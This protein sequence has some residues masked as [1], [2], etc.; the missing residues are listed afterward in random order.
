MR[1]SRQ[2]RAAIATSKVFLCLVTPDWQGD[3]LCQEEARY[4]A[5]LQKPFLVFVWPGVRLAEDAFQ[6]VRDLRITQLPAHYDVAMI[7]RQIQAWLAAQD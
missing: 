4:A 5:Q 2:H 1:L 7:A 3:S 6:G